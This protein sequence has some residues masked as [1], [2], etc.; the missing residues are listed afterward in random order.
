VQRH[1]H[2]ELAFI[3]FVREQMRV[4]AIHQRG[5]IRLTP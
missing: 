5:V 3:M 1:Q 4:T 2:L